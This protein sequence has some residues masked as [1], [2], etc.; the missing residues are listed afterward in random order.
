M[1]TD[2]VMEMRFLLDL[3]LLIQIA[4]RMQIFLSYIMILREMKA[5]SSLIKAAENTMQQSITQGIQHWE[6]RE[7]RQ[8]VQ[9]LKRQWS[10]ITAFSKLMISTLVKSLRVQEATLFL[11]GLS[12]LIYRET[13]FYLVKP[14]KAFTTEL[15]I[16]PFF[17]RPIGERTPMEPL[18]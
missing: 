8:R 17:I 14:L 10:L 5:I 3:I 13:N 4:P 7:E 18:T 1:A 6:L 12:P 11:H 15:E 9:L 16:M 2:I